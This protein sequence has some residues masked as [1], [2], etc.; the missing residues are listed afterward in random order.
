MQPRIHDASNDLICARALQV[1]VEQN[2]ATCKYLVTS[3]ESSPPNL[4]SAIN[5]TMLEESQEPIIN[6]PE[7]SI[8]VMIPCNLNHQLPGLRKP[9]SLAKKSQRCPA[10]IA[11]GS[12]SNTSWPGSRRTSARACNSGQAAATQRQPASQPASQPAR[13][14]ARP[15]RQTAKTDRQPARQAARISGYRAF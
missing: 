9:P 3:Q 15:D 5:T 8:L 11:S 4:D 10:S 12:R 1:F 2:V 13:Q 14:T 6:K 7:F